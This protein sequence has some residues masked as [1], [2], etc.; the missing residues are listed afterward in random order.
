MQIVYKIVLQNIK[1]V[2]IQ[3]HLFFNIV[4]YNCFEN[5]FFGKNDQWRN[6]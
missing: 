1:T 6:K 3:T 4:E 2:K 5:A